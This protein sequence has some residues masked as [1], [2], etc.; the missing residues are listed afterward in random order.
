M[1]PTTLNT[2]NGKVG[3]VYV[4]P[5]GTAAPFTVPPVNTFDITAATL[6]SAWT[7]GNL[8]YLHETDTPTMGYALTTKQITAWQLAGNIMR[9]LS[10]GKIRTIK[11]TCR[12]I[13]KN[14]WNQVEPGST[15]LDAANGSSVVTVPNAS[16]NPYRAG[17]IEI[18]DLDQ[19][20]KMWVYIPMM[21]INAL[22]DLKFDE[23]ETTNAQLT[24][25]FLSPTGNST[26]PLYYVASNA[27]G[28][29]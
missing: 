3:N 7:N 17:L 6:A 13:N 15:Y 16:T 19:S 23:Q 10:T 24:F 4:V 29:F 26:D 25:T 28:L 5:F 18:Q 8:G 21:Q 22:G 27:P 9:V 1:A 12:E 2:F 14:V 11:F 20:Q